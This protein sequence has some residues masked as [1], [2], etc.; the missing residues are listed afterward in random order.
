MNWRLLRGI[1]LSRLVVMPLFGLVGV[2]LILGAENDVASGL[3]V[4]LLLI[5][6]AGFAQ[7]VVDFRQ[8]GRHL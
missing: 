4:L 3:G 7:A 8:S 1:A 5:V 6:G 2:A